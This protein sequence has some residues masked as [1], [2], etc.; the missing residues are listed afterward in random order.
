MHSELLSPQTFRSATHRRPTASS[1]GFDFIYFFK[2]HLSFVLQ[3][4][5]SQFRPPSQST[6]FVLSHLPAAPAV[7]RFFAQNSY[8]AA[9]VPEQ[10]SF[11]SPSSFSRIHLLTSSGLDGSEHSL[12]SVRENGTIFRVQQRFFFDSP[13]GGFF[14]TFFSARSSSRPPPRKS[15]YLSLASTTPR[16]FAPSLFSSHRGYH[17]NA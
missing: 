7:E 17:H 8:V 15:T 4:S 6:L 10:P 14:Q 11:L 16:L 2:P 9:R 1:P 3:T 5:F 13:T 12:T